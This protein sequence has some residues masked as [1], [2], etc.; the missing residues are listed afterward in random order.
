M[1]HLV[2]IVGP[3]GAGKSQL[4]LHLAQ[5][6]NGEIVSADSRQVYRYM[7]IGTAKPSQKELSLVPHHLINIVNPDED[8]SLAQYQ[9]LA[10]KAIEDIQRRNKLALL[11]GGS[12]LYIWSVLE[13]WGIP[14]VPP[15][16]EFRHRLEKKAA[17]EG[18]DELYQE[19]MKVD[20]ITAQR[21]DQRNVRRIIRALEVYK[22]AQVPLSQLQRK[23]APPFNSLIIGLTTNRREL[24]RRIDLRV[25]EMIKQ[26]LV[27]EVE[28][29][30]NMGYNLNLPAMSGIGYK[31]IGMFLKGELTLAVAIQQIKFETHRFVRHQYAWFGLEDNRIKWFDIQ[32]KRNSEITALVPKFIRGRG[33]R[34]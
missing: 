15:D 3:T 18:K 30:V 32:T 33:K 11:V 29:L 22:G 31:Q 21:V 19:L 24:Y 27:G 34:G 14:R 8:F 26:G 25:D 12:G 6:F 23:Q 16:L 7:D 10:Y 2:A 28:K 17:K 4:A 9:E 13:G 20:P 1:S 5:T